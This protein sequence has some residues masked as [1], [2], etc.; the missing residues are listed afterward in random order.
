[1]AVTSKSPVPRLVKSR[2]LLIFGLAQRCPYA[3]HPSIAS[4]WNRF[5]PYLGKIDG[6]IGNV[7]YGVI[8]NSDD[9]GGYD[10]LCGVAV[11]QFPADPPEFTRLRI[12]PQSYAVF[13]H[14]NHVSDVVST[15]KAIWEHGLAGAGFKALPGPAFERYDERFDPRTGLGELEIW[16]PVSSAG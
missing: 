8:Y 14:R 6:Q 2:E 4:Q 7:A 15:W 5:R 13:E 11:R 9:S 3:G 1:M 12:P 10:Y 16:V